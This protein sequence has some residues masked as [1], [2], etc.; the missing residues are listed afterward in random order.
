M[1][2]I[3]RGGWPY[4]NPPN[5]QFTLNTQS[6]QSKG[7]VAWW[8]TL[9]QHGTSGLLRDYV[10]NRYPMT[11]YNTPTWK[12]DGQLGETMLLD[13]G[14]TEYCERSG[15]VVS[16]APMTVSLWA[17]LDDAAVNH[18]LFSIGNTGTPGEY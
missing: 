2:L 12:G 18:C 10:A 3:K 4:A 7:L 14:S 5:T 1:P 16:A 6:P 17:R 8:P 15:A 9:G 11:Q 13:D